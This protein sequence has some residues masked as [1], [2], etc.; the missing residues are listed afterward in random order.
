MTRE[1]KWLRAE[2]KIVE[3]AVASERL[4]ASYAGKEDSADQKR[5]RRARADMLRRILAIVEREQAADRFLGGALCALAC[6]SAHDDFDSVLYRETATS[7]GLKEL[8]SE[9]RRQ[10]DGQLRNLLKLRAAL[11]WRDARR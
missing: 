6:I 2:L 8:I 5:H 7:F 1:Q 9:A 10:K 11:Q 4:R 3:D